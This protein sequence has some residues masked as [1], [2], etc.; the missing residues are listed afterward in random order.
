[1]WACSE[2]LPCTS[3]C[4]I[5]RYCPS[6]IEEAPLKLMDGEGDFARCPG[7]AQPPR[8]SAP[9]AR[10]PKAVRAPSGRMSVCPGFAPRGAIGAIAASGAHRHGDAKVRARKLP[11]DDLHRAPVSRD[12]LEHNRQPDAPALDRAAP[13]SAPGV[14]GLE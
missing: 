1:M 8:R 14:E 10:A 3:R 7:P 6:A 11:V 9:Q 13:G 12:E 2:A 5:C 4:S